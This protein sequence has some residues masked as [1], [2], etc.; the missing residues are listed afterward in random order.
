M[1]DVVG[2][3]KFVWSLTLI[4]NVAAAKLLKVNGVVPAV[5]VA[6]SSFENSYGLVPFV[7]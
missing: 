7:H 2:V 5:N 4:L 3:I 1:T 6:P